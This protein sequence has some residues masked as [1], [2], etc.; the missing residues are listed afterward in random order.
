MDPLYLF[1]RHFD[2]YSRYRNNPR[3]AIPT[4]RRGDYIPRRRNR[5]RNYD[6]LPSYM[7]PTE[8]S[9]RRSRTYGPQRRKPRPWER[10]NGPPTTD[11]P[12]NDAP[13][14]TN[15]DDVPKPKIEEEA[16]A[17]ELAT[18]LTV[19]NI[20]LNIEE[21]VQQHHT[22]KYENT[23]EREDGDGEKLERELVIRR[24]A[25]FQ[26]TIEFDRPYNKKQDDLT[27]LFKTGEYPL[28]KAGTLASFKLQEGADR[29]YKPDSWGAHIVKL[30]GNFMT[31]AVYVPAKCVIG[32]WEFVVKTI[33]EDKDGK[34]MSFRYEYPDDIII[35]LNPWSPDDTVYYPTEKLLDEY[36]L[37]DGGA[38]FYGNYR[39]IGS[40]GWNFGQ[41]ADGI[42]DAS[43][44]ILRKAFGFKIDGNMGDPVHISRALSRI[45]NNNDDNGVLV[46]NWSG[47]YDDGTRPTAWTGSIKIIQQYMEKREPVQYGQCWVFSGVLTTICRALGLPCRSVT[48]FASAHDTD[49]SCTIDNVYRLDD[50]D[51]LEKTNL[52]GDS[53]WNFHV[54]NEVYMQRP[55]LPTSSTEY[56]GWQVI[57]ATPQERSDG[58]FCLGPAPVAAVKKGAINIGKDTP[59]VFAEV[60]ADSIDWLVEDRDEFYVLNVVKD[61][62]GKKI[63]TKEP[64]GKRFRGNL[65][66]TGRRGNID[67][68]DLTLLYK[69]EEGTPEER[70]AVAL[71]TKLSNADKNP[72]ITDSM[73]ELKL[74]DQDE[75][76]VGKDFSY[77]VMVKNVGDKSLTVKVGMK[78][79]SMTYYGDAVDMII[80]KKFGE[81][82]IEAGQ[83]TK[84]KLDVPADLYLPK[85]IEHFA[86]KVTATCLIIEEHRRVILEDDFRLR[87]PDLTIEAPETCKPGET[88][89]IKVYFDNPM[90]KTLTKCKLMIEGSLRSTET[91]NGGSIKFPDVPGNS[92]WETILTVK[93][94][95]KPTHIKERD[96]F[97]SFDCV[98][99][100]DIV[101]FHGL[102]LSD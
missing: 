96:L 9:F 28:P 89:K 53:V 20:D 79:E 11:H 52:S 29:S 91:T 59:F 101:G 19:K 8:S 51:D 80:H 70:D 2:M 65:S 26:I 56:H 82:K 18:V 75:I 46:G 27:F 38:L 37:N 5:H 47:E 7:R 45:V 66:Y 97:L 58:F 6:G 74:E 83:E 87:R 92:R 48:N 31:M 61:K 57:D 23:M 64:T 84:I 15:T 94:K 63:S 81:M 67:R 42:L 14:T 95:I 50:D 25:E 73:I 3:G 12:A 24:A 10:D 43:L 35:L 100:P 17:E 99:L 40:R 88:I 77:S 98:E 36:V 72:Y 41:F 33:F 22:D 21:N 78:I 13:D 93:P 44:V 30:D 76:L 60:N 49:L 86:M 68:E 71:A 90:N 55:D 69:Y 39:Q 16:T 102:D 1:N 85:V 62:I 54:W 32:E 4:D 34:K